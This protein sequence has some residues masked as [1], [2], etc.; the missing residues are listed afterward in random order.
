MGGTV[1]VGLGVG[2][3]V[4]GSVGPPVVK[5]MLDPLA[6]FIRAASRMSGLAPPGIAI[7]ACIL[8]ESPSPWVT[9]QKLSVPEPKTLT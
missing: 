9:G 1:V 7:M 8:S 2:V 4:G 6:P 3:W 5:L